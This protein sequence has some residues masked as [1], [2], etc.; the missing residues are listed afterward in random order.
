[1]KAG[2][3]LCDHTRE[4]LRPRFGDYPETFSRMLDE[5]T[6]ESTV[7]DLTEGVFPKSHDDEDVFF[8]TGS[9]KSCFE[10]SNFS[11]Q[12]KQFVLDS[13]QRGTRLIGI[14]FGHQMITHA[15]GGLVERSSKGWGIG[16]HS[17]RLIRNREHF[18]D[19]N[20]VSGLVA[21]RDQVIK[22]AANAIIHATSDFCP[23]GI[24][25][26]GDNIISAQCHPE[27]SREY[28]KTIL[29]IRAEEIGE[30]MCHQAHLD[31]KKSTDNHLLVHGML[32]YIGLST[33]N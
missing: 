25:S 24:V 31:L 14:C 12:L 10:D 3:L 13:Q 23:Y 15:L 29:E 18:D 22:P 16:I 30:Q 21:H 33:A 1:M 9:K 4:H 28:L 32:S 20:F 11:D 26:Y 6:I 19:R 17:Y 5:L 27:L 2:I 8:I 7:Y